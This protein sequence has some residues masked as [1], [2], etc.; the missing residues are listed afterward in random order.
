LKNLGLLGGLALIANYGAGP[1]TVTA[2]IRPGAKDVRE[3]PKAL[4]TGKR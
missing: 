2:A 1:Y 4:F 3:L